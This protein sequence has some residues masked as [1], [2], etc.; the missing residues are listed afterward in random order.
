MTI[1]RIENGQ[2]FCRV[3]RHNG[4]VYLAGMTADDLTGDTTNQ[5]EQVLAKIDSS[6]VE[7]SLELAQ[8]QL[9][10]A[11]QGVEE[12]KANLNQAEIDLRRTTALASKA[13]TSAVTSGLASKADAATVTAA[14]ALK[15]DASAL[16]AKADASALAAKADSSAVNTALDGKADT[17]NGQAV[18]SGSVDITA[19][20][21]E[22]TG[23]DVQSD[24][25]G[26]AAVV[27]GKATLFTQVY[28]GADWSATP[29]GLTAD[30]LLIATSTSRGTGPISPPPGIR[31]GRIWFFRKGT[32]EV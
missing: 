3:L 23:G 6:N 17:V 19:A 28:D 2:R 24:L 10:S 11:S 25:D 7:Q 15:A 27:D 5:T 22:S 13:D 21:I 18:S 9:A 4:T 14:L 1:E 30:D 20:D 31:E 8:A 29:T 26:L 16:A 32:P 12:T